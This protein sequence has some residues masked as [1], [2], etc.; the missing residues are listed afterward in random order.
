MFKVIFGRCDTRVIDFDYALKQLYHGQKRNVQLDMRNLELTVLQRQ[1]NRGKKGWGLRITPEN[2][3]RNYAVHSQKIEA[4]WKLNRNLRLEK[5]VSSKQLRLAV[6]IDR[7][8]KKNKTG[9]FSEKLAIMLIIQT[10][11]SNNTDTHNWKKYRSW[12]IVCF[13]ILLDIT[14]TL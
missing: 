1:K 6:A 10:W 4:R 12:Y 13:L 7:R 3:N 14:Y 8:W 2:E 9:S 11:C 5:V